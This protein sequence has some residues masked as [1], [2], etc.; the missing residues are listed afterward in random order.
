MKKLTHM[1]LHNQVFFFPKGK[2]FKCS[3]VLVAHA[4]N[5]SC[6]EGRNQE[7]QSSEPAQANSSRDPISK[8]PNTKK[9]GGVAQGVGP[10]SPGTRKKKKKN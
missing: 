4:C 10:A 2:I 5:P 7:D 6:S 8:I 1:A 9:A 3:R